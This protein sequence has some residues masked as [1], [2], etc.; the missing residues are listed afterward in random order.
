ML[1][2]YERYGVDPSAALKQAQITPP[3]LRRPG[4]RITAAQM[5]AFSRLAMQQLD[6]EALGWFSRR[7]PWGSYGL[8]SR[9][10]LTAPTLGVALKRWCR[11]HALLTDD[12]VFRL[13]VQSGVA[14]VQI[15]ERREL[16]A[17]RE[18]CLLTSL[19]N[20]HGYASW[21]VDSRISLV[22]TVF[23][24]G[25]PPHADVYP[26]LFPGPVRFGAPQAALSFDARYLALPQRRDERA[27][28]AML[29]HAV[30][31]IVLPYRRDRLLAERVRELLHDRGA[32][33]RSAPALADALH[34]SA[35]TLHRQLRDEGVALQALKDEVRREQ[36]IDQLRRTARPI[37][38]IALAAGFSN[39][40]SFSRAFKAW[41]GLSP[42]AFR[43]QT[44]AAA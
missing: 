36:A 4:T 30:R 5:E 12:I 37:K 35:R 29:Q 38:Q 43:A 16:G 41:T 39:E 10:S 22:E 8:L 33:L 44:D 18:L 28:Q 13:G 15:D 26:R 21:V 20:L 14:R 31:L 17:M 9:A 25:R 19:R 40:K 1:L 34:L 11:H 7:L 6:D 42:T 27:L 23:P 32:E 24:F 3:M 2:A